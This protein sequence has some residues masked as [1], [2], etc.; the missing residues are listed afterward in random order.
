MGHSAEEQGVII[1]FNLDSGKIQLQ[2]GRVFQ[3]KASDFLEQID[4]LYDY[5]GIFCQIDGDR[6]FNIR[7]NPDLVV[8][9]P[10]RSGYALL[11]A[12][13]CPECSWRL[14]MMASKE[15]APLRKRQSLDCP[16][17]GI[18]LSLRSL[19]NGYHRYTIFGLFASYAIWNRG[20]NFYA[21]TGATNP[22][23]DLLYAITPFFYLTLILLFFWIFWQEKLISTPRE[24]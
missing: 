20:V 7:K 9:K 23:P 3:F 4:N 18:H 11:G 2:D 10:A 17:C 22:D 6:A 15:Q 16:E 13:R 24:E 8:T 12:A 1:Q 19:V 21:R 14:P 5:P